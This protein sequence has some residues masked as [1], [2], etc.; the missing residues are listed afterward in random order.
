[1]HETYYRWQSL[2]C[3]GIGNENSF[4]ANEDQT[5]S[6]LSSQEKHF[7]CQTTP[8]V[9]PSIQCQFYFQYRVMTYL[10]RTHKLS[11]LVT[12]TYKFEFLRNA[13][14]AIQSSTSIQINESIELEL[15][16][17]H[18]VGV[19][20]PKKRMIWSCKS[21]RTVLIVFDSQLFMSIHLL[22]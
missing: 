5:N 6:R 14:L 8:T 17:T 21:I 4:K 7:Q 9:Y 18:F 2:I 13:N 15:Y 11:P 1:M 16:L 3:I 12:V 20:K 22:I 19:F 10:Y